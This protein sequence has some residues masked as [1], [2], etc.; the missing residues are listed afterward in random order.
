MEIFIWKCPCVLNIVDLLYIMKVI[1]E[2][3]S[4]EFL[5]PNSKQ[6]YYQ[7]LENPF[8]L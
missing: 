5:V 4:A 7:R 1:K 2:D 3:I 6:P 8:M